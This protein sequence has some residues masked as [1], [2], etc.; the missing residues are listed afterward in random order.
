MAAP[1]AKVAKKPM[2]SY[3]SIENEKYK[4][5]EEKETYTGDEQTK[6]W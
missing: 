2:D 6:W 4:E 3:N 5:A 1:E